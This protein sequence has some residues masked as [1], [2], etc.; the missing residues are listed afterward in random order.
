MK[1]LLAPESTS[2]Y[3][4]MASFVVIPKELFLDI[5]FQGSVIYLILCLQS[6]HI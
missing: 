3:S 5:N 2:L 1:T 4:T 6:N